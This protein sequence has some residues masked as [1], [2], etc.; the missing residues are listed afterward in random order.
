MILVG[1][2]MVFYQF[3][4]I[5]PFLNPL[6]SMFRLRLLFKGFTE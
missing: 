4:N 5:L 1:E 6:L 3:K 2:H